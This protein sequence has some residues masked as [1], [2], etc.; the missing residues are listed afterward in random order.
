V[1]FLGLGLITST[2]VQMAKYI[3]QIRKLTYSHFKRKSVSGEFLFLKNCF[4]SS[5]ELKNRQNKSSFWQTPCC[6]ME[7][8][9]LRIKTFTCRL[10]LSELLLSTAIGRTRSRDRC[11]A[12]NRLS[13]RPEPSGRVVHEEVWWIGHSRTTWSTVC[14]SAPHSQVADETISHLYKQERKRPTPVRRRLSRTQTVP[15]RIIRRGCVPVLGMK[16]RS[17]IGLSS[18]VTP[19]SIC[20]PPRAPHVCCCCQM[21][22]WVVVRLVRMGVS[23]RDAVH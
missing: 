16:V 18:P 23:I 22:W 21:N 10:L 20:H 15:E 19:P 4:V 17:L 11:W 14:S 12:A 6:C 7:M 13:H 1:A 8:F 5:F 9:M 2:L 3:L